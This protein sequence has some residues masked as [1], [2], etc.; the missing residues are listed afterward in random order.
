LKPDVLEKTFILDNLSSPSHEKLRHIEDYLP[1]AK[2]FAKGGKLSSGHGRG[3]FNLDP[4]ILW[5]WTLQG[6]R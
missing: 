1:R 4:H 3:A 5:D 2:L 6:P